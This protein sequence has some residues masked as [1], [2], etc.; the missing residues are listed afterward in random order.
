MSYVPS[1]GFRLLILPLILGVFITCHDARATATGQIIFVDSGA[2]R[3]LTG[4]RLD[5]DLYGPVSRISPTTYIY[6]IVQKNGGVQARSFDEREHPENQIEAVLNFVKIE[7]VQSNPS[8][9]SLVDLN[10]KIQRIVASWSDIPA[11]SDVP[12]VVF[13][14]NWGMRANKKFWVSERVWPDNCVKEE[15]T[16]KLPALPKLQVVF[17]PSS[18]GLQPSANAMRS[19]MRAISS[20]EKFRNVKY[21]GL[22]RPGCIAPE[23]AG[24]LPGSDAAA[25]SCSFSDLEE[26]PRWSRV[27]ICTPPQQPIA[28]VDKLMPSSAVITNKG[29]LEG[30]VQLRFLNATGLRAKL[31]IGQ[32]ELDGQDRI[33]RRDLRRG[34]TDVEV[35]LV[36]DGNC[37]AGGNIQLRLEEI[38]GS[39]ERVPLKQV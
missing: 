23:G 16:K 27:Q 6:V 34:R 13:A 3:G 12:V 19:F 31:R 9:I 35:I 17:R 8:V 25:T 26:E 4:E 2:Y 21:G 30:D 29:T 11:G 32:R 1:F 18:G 33:A 10:E 38:S 24:V 15:L 14:N 22:V 36:R 39:G 5:R 37:S 20:D 28:A 7:Q